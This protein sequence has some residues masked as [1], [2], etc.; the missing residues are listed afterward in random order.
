M[1]IEKGGIINDF[2]EPN[3]CQYAIPVYQRNYEWSG[4]Q[5]RKLFDD[6]VN[7][8]MNDHMHFCG[9]IIYA[10]LKQE[11][12]INYYV[13]IDGQQRLTTIFLMIKALIDT[14]DT[15]ADKATLRSACSTRT[16]SRSTT[17]TIPAS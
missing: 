1:R 7:A 8:H 3:K 2:I 4:E 6:V 17:L 11:K 16:S 9:S 13:I 10:L 14:A 5:C 12:K 15:E